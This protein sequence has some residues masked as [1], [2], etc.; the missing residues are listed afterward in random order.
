MNR[1]CAANTRKAVDW[2]KKQTPIQGGISYRPQPGWMFKT[3]LRLFLPQLHFYVFIVH[4]TAFALGER[5]EGC[6]GRILLS[7]C[8]SQDQTHFC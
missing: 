8:Y 7:G 4:C 3:P 6:V 5:H 2:K 1:V